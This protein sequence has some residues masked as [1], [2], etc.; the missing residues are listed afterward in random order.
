MQFFILVIY[1]AAFS[2]IGWVSESLICSIAEKKV[3][4]RG[5]LQGPFIPVYGFGG[6][7]IVYILA[8]FQENVLALYVVGVVACTLLEYITAIFCETVFKTKLWDYSQHRFHFQGR[9]WVVS[10]LF[11]GLLGLFCVYVIYPPFRDLIMSIPN[12]M[13]PWISSAFLAYFAA[14]TCFSTVTILRMNGR[15]GQI[16]ETISEIRS[17]LPEFK[18]TTPAISQRMDEFR[19]KYP[20]LKTIS[21]RLQSQLKISWNQRRLINA[22]PT[23]RSKRYNEQLDRVREAI[24]DLRR[25]RKVRR[26]EKKDKVHEKNSMSKD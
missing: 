24:E 26:P 19:Q 10:S 1:F 5:F 18:I 12:H 17:K 11:F 16:A 2:F 13:V 7:I 3:V 25:Q 8:P 23:M 22:F 20:D 21:E 15:L 6:L 14:D 9:V 4:N